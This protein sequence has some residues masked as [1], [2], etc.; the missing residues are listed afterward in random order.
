MD[1]ITV[2]SAL[3]SMNGDKPLTPAMVGVIWMMADKL[4]E[5]RIPANISDAVWLEI[6]SRQLRPA[7]GRTDNVW[8][9]TVL[10][11]LLGMKISGEFRGDAWGA[12]ML[13]Q[14]E[15]RQNGALTRL[16]VPPAAV[17]V[18]RAPETFAKIEYDAAY[19]LKGAAR[20]LYAALADKKRLGRPYWEYLLPELKKICQADGK[21]SYDR[22]N[23]F[24]Q[25]V[26]DP[27]VKEIN[28]YGTV[29]LK[30]TAI[31]QGRAIV[32]VRFDWKWK[33]IDAA[34]LTAEENAQPSGARNMNRKENPAPPLTETI[35]LE[36]LIAARTQKEQDEQAEKLEHSRQVAAD[37][38]AFRAWLADNPG[39]NMTAYVK[40]KKKAAG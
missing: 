2:S 24:K 36:E 6:P 39:G 34:Q 18:I 11:R 7:D 12:V 21:K 5:R 37:K 10:D 15:I 3:I 22:W 35:D 33:S 31:K 9:R 26:L 32:G 19:L 28:E 13:A 25:W 38:A 27:A 17:K 14:Y 20:L 1:S 29:E 16:L 30:Y 8:L 4:D 40:E 23:N